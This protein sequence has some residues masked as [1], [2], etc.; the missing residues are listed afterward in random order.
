VSTVKAPLAVPG[1]EAPKGTGVLTSGVGTSVG[2]RAAEAMPK[3]S[4][5]EPGIALTKRIFPLLLE[6]G[7]VSA[8]GTRR[9]AVDP[10]PTR[11]MVRPTP[12]VTTTPSASDKASA[13][14]VRPAG[15]A[16]MST[17]LVGT[18]TGA[19]TEA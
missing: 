4:E 16:L 15:I 14:Q 10:P 3:V 12:E 17:L 18:P 1:T 19:L 2:R 13:S 9:S 6:A 5:A 8:R 7:V 11:A